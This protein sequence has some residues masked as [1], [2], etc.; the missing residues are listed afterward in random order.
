MT[1]FHINNSGNCRIA[2]E[3]VYHEKVLIKHHQ[4][5]YS[6]F[7][8]TI[9]PNSESKIRLQSNDKKAQQYLDHIANG[10]KRFLQTYTENDISI[11]G[12]DIKTENDK[13]HAVDSKPITYQI[14]IIQAI[15]R[16]IQEQ[17]T[18]RK[19][20]K[21]KLKTSQYYFEVVEN[22]RQN[23]NLEWDGL[24]TNQI[25]RKF[26]KTKCVNINGTI[27]LVN[28][29]FDITLENSDYYY[30]SMKNLI[31]LRFK[32]NEFHYGEMLRYL[33]IMNLIVLDEYKQNINPSGFILYIEKKNCIKKIETEKKMLTFEWC[34]R[35]ILSSETVYKVTNEADR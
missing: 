9:T 12:F 6:N 35:N 28:C 19:V 34:L 7:D 24:S 18:I 8:L 31:Q 26:E 2:F 4:G 20:I 15:K 25:I 33:N 16:I 3:E 13:F 29:D 32:K 22:K 11:N 14:P 23:R 27:N 30:T 1:E 17:N 21:P 10:I 5:I